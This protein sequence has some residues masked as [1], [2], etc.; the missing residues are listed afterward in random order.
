VTN[1][2]F[3]NK[4]GFMMNSPRVIGH[5]FM[6]CGGLKTVWLRLHI[7]PAKRVQSK[8][9]RPLVRTVEAVTGVATSSSTASAKHNLSHL[10][11]FL[12]SFS[13]HH[14]T[15]LHAFKF[16]LEPIL[17]ASIQY[18]E[19]RAHPTY[20]VHIIAPLCAFQDVFHDYTLDHGLGG[21][22]HDHLPPPCRPAS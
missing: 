17:T 6:F 9:H 11:F 1:G 18:L 20:T 4:K 14:H 2:R 12:P 15:S 19:F 3:Q 21:L 13:Q 8:H 22:R 7:F 16:A 10:F 5:G